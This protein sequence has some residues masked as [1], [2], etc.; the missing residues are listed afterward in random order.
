[1]P[2]TDIQELF[3]RLMALF[4]DAAGLAAF[5]QQRGLGKTAIADFLDEITVAHLDAGR[6]IGDVAERSGR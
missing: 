3:A 6:L 4:E 2:D 1:M 5:A